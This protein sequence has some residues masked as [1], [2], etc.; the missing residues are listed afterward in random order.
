MGRIAPDT[1]CFEEGVKARAAGQGRSDNPYDLQTPEHAD[2]DA[3]WTARYDLD[4]ESDPNSDRDQPA[5]DL[6][7]GADD[8]RPPV[9]R[10]ASEP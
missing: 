9:D 10:P 4:E 7:D 1:Q 3:G 2:W 5:D 6:E 8:L